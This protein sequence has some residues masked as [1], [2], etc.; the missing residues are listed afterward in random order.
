MNLKEISIK[1]NREIDLFFKKIKYKENNFFIKKQ[2]E[3][4]RNFCLSEGKK[5]RP[6]LSLLIYQGLE[7]KKK[8]IL[9]PIISLELYHNHTLIHDDIYDEDNFRRNKE[10]PHFEFKKWFEK[11]YEISHLSKCLYAGEFERLGAVSGFI[12][13]KILRSLVD[14]AI[15]NSKISSKEK[16]KIFEIYQKLDISDNFGQSLDLLFEKEE[17]ISEKDYF[18]M[19]NYKTGG[20]FKASVNIGA[21]L[22]ESNQ[23]QHFCLEKYAENIA[24]AFQIK[25]D[26]LDISV[27]GN[28]GREKGSDIIQRKKTLLFIYALQ[29]EQNEKKE[30]L[31]KYLNKKIYSTSDIEKIINL[32]HDLG[33][34][35]RCKKIAE[36]KINKALYWLNH[37]DLKIRKKEKDILE[38]LSFFIYRREK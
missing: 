10:T 9:L 17:K 34:V 12:N 22:T 8:E 29:G 32:Y 3:V 13:G 6:I 11:K 26:L 31:K 30:I 14:Y 36:E 15:I 35:E 2:I 24:L 25:D 5:I 4:L 18:K 19:V 7:K 38:N 23:K 21:I 1:I 37:K 20:L 33:A 16:E 27:E 28:K